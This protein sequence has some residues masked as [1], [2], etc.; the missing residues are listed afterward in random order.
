MP[1]TRAR[2]RRPTDTR[3]ATPIRANRSPSGIHPTHA[4][5]PH[6]RLIVRRANPISNPTQPARQRGSRPTRNRSTRRIHLGDADLLDKGR[7]E[8]SRLRHQRDACVEERFPRGDVGLHGFIGL[9]AQLDLIRER[10]RDSVAGEEDVV[11]K[12]ELALREWY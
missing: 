10:M 2:L 5:T 1:R 4:P 9:Y 8:V 6:M 3:R 11:V 7:L 12:E